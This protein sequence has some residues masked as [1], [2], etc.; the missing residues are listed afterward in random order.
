MYS[1][2]I[3]FGP[4]GTAWAYLF[5][6]EEKASVIY[7]AY[8]NNK[9]T[10]DVEDGVLIG[11]DDFGQSFAIPFNDIHGM[12]LEDLDQ[13]VHA[14]IERSLVDA[15]AQMMFDKRAKT[16]P[17]IAQGI[18]ERQQTPVLTPMGGFPR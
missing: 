10:N 2:T 8:V 7:N 16:D 11:A 12:M 17:V 1:L 4:T 6:E 13:I 3:C 14:R 18:R 9:L 5:K 15:R